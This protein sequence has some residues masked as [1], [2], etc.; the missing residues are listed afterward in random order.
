MVG[1]IETVTTE[2]ARGL[3]GNSRI[4]REDVV[5]VTVVTPQKHRTTNESD[6][7]FNIVRRPSFLRLVKLIR[8]AD[9]L[10]LAGTDMLPLLLGWLL[11]VRTVI[12]HHGFQTVCPNG[13]ML[14]EPTQSFCPGHYMAG[15]HLQCLKCNRVTR[16]V[17]QGVKAWFL[18]LPR[19]W[20]CQRANVNV[21]P[22]A[23]L[24]TILRLPRMITIHHGLP[25]RDSCS[26]TAG[27]PP[28]VVFVGRLVSTK[29]VHTLL[30]AAAQLEDCEFR[31]NVIGD[32][33]ER[34]RLET[35]ARTLG[36]ESRV[37]FH[38]YLP[39]DKVEQVLTTARV[40]VVPSVA[41]EVFGLVALENMFR[42][43]ALIVS[44]MGSLAEVIADAGLTFPP[45]DVD[46]L[47]RC[48][49]QVLQCGRLAEEMGTRAACR[50]KTLFTSARM[51]EDHLVLYWRLVN[52]FPGSPAVLNSSSVPSL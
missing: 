8:D 46:A 9:V 30:K 32:G 34:T 31:L 25:V 2:L 6:L 35:D 42:R 39:I 36:L 47:A 44:E 13:Q 23:W 52:L 49:R 18:T 48:L 4:S 14:Y 11:R 17:I 22:T 50:A 21:M 29:G 38:G 45:G 12:E 33:P 43:K 28:S 16:G 37:I 19:R 20:L 15:R 10:H 51:V 41:G 7:P 3:A 24:G 1:G 5:K 27:G 40:V 26:S